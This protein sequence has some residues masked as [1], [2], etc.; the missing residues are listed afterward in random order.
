M[1]AALLKISDYVNAYPLFNRYTRNTATIFMMHAISDDG[2]IDG[3][4][5]T[6]SLLREYFS[7]LKAHRYRVVSL[8]QYVEALTHKKNTYKQVIFTVDD[9]YK[10]FYQKAFQ[11]FR[12]YGYPATIFL[13]TDFIERKL[14]FWWNAIEYACLSTTQPHV[15]LP[16]IGLHRVDLKDMEQRKSLIES[17][18]SI[19]KKMENAGKL[20]F[21]ASL[22]EKL[23]VD[24]GRQ[25]NGIYEPLDWD[26]ILEMQ[27]A[28]IE[29]YP[30]TKTHPI[31]SRIPDS[32]LKEEVEVPKKI[33]EQ[34]L[35]T[36]ADVFCYPN[37]GQD[38]FNEKTIS[39]LKDSGYIAAVTGMPGFE[40]TMTDTD[41]YR[42]KR[43]HLPM[44]PIYFRQY[45]SGLERFKRKA[46]A[47]LLKR[48][49]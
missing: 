13:T 32:Q 30:H 18:V 21:I 43:F 49:H 2:A 39:A 11:I 29:F 8:T 36:R 15:D 41:M 16:E 1:K 24:V 4:G 3:G 14:F 44:D 17:I 37:G 45:I 28:G 26:E 9:G 10:D 42:I 31:M 19:C 46:L 6:P 47:G 27:N 12:E 5:I 48:I 38:D 22:I 7:Y 25:P 34:R 20:D 23:E 35:G 33:I 40:D